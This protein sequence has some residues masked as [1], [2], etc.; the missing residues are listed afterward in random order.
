VFD[1]VTIGSDEPLGVTKLKIGKA[2]ISLKGKNIDWYDLNTQGKIQIGLTVTELEYP[3]WPPQKLDSPPQKNPGKQGKDVPGLSNR[4]TAEKKE[5]LGALT[6]LQQ[7]G[8]CSNVMELEITHLL[9]KHFDLLEEN[10][11]LIQEKN[12][13][14][15]DCSEVDLS[16]AQEKLSALSEDLRVS[17]EETNTL[18]LEVAHLKDLQVIKGDRGGV[19]RCETAPPNVVAYSN[20]LGS[21]EASEEERQMPGDDMPGQVFEDEFFVVQTLRDEVF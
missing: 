6:V 1:N 8:V 17:R 12:P 3:N 2:L 16:L 5:E 21:P 7:L 18:R 4:I 11:K 14:I 10:K 20:P 13:H 19:W 15:N 9:K